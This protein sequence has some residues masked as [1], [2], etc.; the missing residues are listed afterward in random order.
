MTSFVDS[1]FIS[2]ISSMI[3]K[4]ASAPFELWRIQRQNSFIPHSS[5]RAVLK[6]EGLRYLWP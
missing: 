4:T 2:S 1:F 3:S 5:L 6:K